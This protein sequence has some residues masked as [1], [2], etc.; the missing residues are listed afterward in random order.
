MSCRPYRSSVRATAARETR[1]RIVAAAA[2]RLGA[3]P[4]K[5]F[6]LEAVAADAGVTRLTVYNQFG[7]GR[8]LLEAVFDEIAARA[9]MERLAQAASEPEAGKAVEK[10]VDQFCAFWEAGRQ[11]HI[12]LQAARAADPD[13]DEALKERNERRRRLLGVIIGRLVDAGELKAEAGADLVDMLFVL[14]SVHVYVELSSGREPEAVR[15]LIHAM[16]GDALYGARRR[17]QLR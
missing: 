17:A 1:S 13:L 6:S 7:G 10:V 12:R 2:E 16:A 9:G 5:P 15:T 11:T 8:A 4:Y 14:T 3:V